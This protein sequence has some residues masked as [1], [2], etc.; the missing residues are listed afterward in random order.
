MFERVLFA[1]SLYVPEAVEAA[2][3]AFADLAKL[4][5]IARDD[6]IELTVSDADPDVADV[7]LDELSNYVLAETIA[8]SRG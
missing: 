1:R 7:L 8:R 4:E 3:R 5:V 6:S 2:A